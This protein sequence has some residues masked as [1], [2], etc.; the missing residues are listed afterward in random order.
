MIPTSSFYNMMNRTSGAVK[1]PRNF[2]SIESFIMHSSYSSN[3]FFCKGRMPILYSSNNDWLNTENPD[4]VNH[5]FRPTHL[6]KI[7]QTIVSFNAIFMV[8]FNAW[9][10]FPFKRFDYKAMYHFWKRLPMFRQL[11]ISIARSSYGRFQQARRFLNQTTNISAIANFI[12][13]FVS[14]YRFPT[15]IHISSIAYMAVPYRA[16]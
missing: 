11:N 9:R 16:L 8:Y 5:I 12:K 4:S 13:S 7:L 6:F 2:S 10:D 1:F 14:K 15:L 3:L